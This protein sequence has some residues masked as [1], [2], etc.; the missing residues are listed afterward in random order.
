MTHNNYLDTVRKRLL[1][2]P[3]REFA[4]LWKQN[5][6]ISITWGQ[7]GAR[8]E[9][10]AAAYQAAD[11]GPGDVIFIILRH[12]PDLYA[13]FFGA[14]LIGAVPS[15]LPFPSAKQD[16]EIYWTN[17]AAVFARTG[18]A[19]LIADEDLCADLSARGFGAR[20]ALLSPTAIS[21]VG[22]ALPNIQDENA[23]AL[24]QHSSGTTGLK[25]GVSLSYRAIRLQLDAY[26]PTLGLEAT[27]IIASWLPLYH[28]MGLIACLLLPAYL[29]I[30]IVALDPFEWAA[31][32]AALLEAIE[33]HRATH[34]WV[35]NFALDHLVRAVPRGATF[36]LSSIV[37]MIGCSE[38]NK[39]A[40]FDRFIARYC[41]SGVDETKLQT[42]YAMAETVFAVSQSRIG[43]PPRRLSVRVENGHC[44]RSTEVGALALLSNGPPIAGA[45]FG[46]EANGALT[47]EEG[48][49]GELCVSH[50]SMFDGYFAASEPRENLFI[51]G[52]FRTGDI[53]FIDEG[54]VFISG[55]KKDL[56]VINGRNYYAHDIEDVANS[57]NGVRRGRCVA[58]GVHLQVIGSEQ[59]VLIAEREDI[60]SGSESIVIAAINQAMNATFGMPAG[61]IELVEPGWLVKTTS[62]KISRSENLRKYLSEIEGGGNFG[63]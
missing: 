62:G 37:A 47:R 61:R 10:Y 36:D 48:V 53:G 59:L 40:S 55:R 51:E 42:C 46:I 32:P 7:L 16:P 8:S 57:V 4:T 34:V 49:V 63:R 22:L 31:R 54:E 1:H 58:L 15:M 43:H 23:I 3:D 2:E 9:S 45:T 30:P 6:R 33:A 25:K 56:I 19:V 60:T 52:L 44:S 27:S 18:A 50:V 24:L 11:V 38:P 14:M 41:S 13:A 35:P 21:D 5:L 12:Q 39:P 28:D 20:M 29:G 26:A 17:H